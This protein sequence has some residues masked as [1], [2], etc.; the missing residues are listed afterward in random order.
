MVV[1]FP[2][3]AQTAAQPSGGQGGAV[4]RNQDSSQLQAAQRFVDQAAMINMT[5]IEAAQSAQKTTNLP[6]YK[7]FAAMIVT[8]HTNMGQNLKRIASTMPGLNVPAQLDQEHRQ[9]VAQLQQL[10]GAKFEQSYRQSQIDGHQK[11]IKLF[12]EFANGNAGTP[13]LRSWAQ[14][15]LPVLQKHLQSAENLPVANEQV[16]AATTNGNNGRTGAGM[17]AMGNAAS[18][19]GQNSASGNGMTTGK[20]NA[21]KQSDAQSLVNEAAQMIKTMQKDPELA[22]A[23]KNAKGL[24][25]VPDFGRGAALVGVR[26]GAG[27]VT[28][29]ENGRWSDPA[30]YDFGAI[31][32]GPQVGASGGQVAF[33]LMSQGAVDA[34]KSGNKFSLNAGAGL[35]IVNYSANSQASW[36]KGDI[37][38]WSN[39]SGAYVG[40]TIS[41]TDINWDD[42]NNRTYYGRNVDMTKILDGAVSNA[43]AHDLKAALP[44]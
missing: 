24:Y 43:G 9:K 42:D 7:D 27:L 38:M 6:A 29:R 31:S 21:A 40:A 3:V 20:A 2:A 4:V 34:F 37:V 15:S 10:S 23:M 12:Q 36:G 13:D 17:R 1:T 35:S 14:A 8:D 26:G 28:V 5:E 16:G 39:T 33:L 22:Q 25:L 19:A 30:F 18:N 44:G 11:A 41:V 32:V